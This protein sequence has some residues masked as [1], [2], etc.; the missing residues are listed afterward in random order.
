MTYDQ[1]VRRKP[2]RK[3]TRICT[4]FAVARIVKL[5]SFHPLTLIYLIY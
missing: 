5:D 3:S 4:S 1:V 2:P